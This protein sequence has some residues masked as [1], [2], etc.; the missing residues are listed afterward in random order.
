MEQPHSSVIPGQS[1]STALFFSAQHRRLH[2]LIVYLS[3]LILFFALIFYILKLFI[4]TVL[5]ILQTLQQQRIKL[6]ALTVQ[7]HFH[8]FFM[9]ICLFVD[10]FAYQCIIDI[11]DRYNLDFDRDLF[12]LQ[13]VRIAPCRHNAHDAICRFAWPAAPVLHSDKYRRFSG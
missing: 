11:C 12:A 7:D 4:D 1:N 2:D 10:T 9:R 3:L 6:S 8:C 13:S 5:N